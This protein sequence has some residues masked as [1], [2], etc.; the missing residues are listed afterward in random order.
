[1]NAEIRALLR[2]AWGR[3]FTD[4]ER[5]VYWELVAEWTAAARRPVAVGVAA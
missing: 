1:M 5:A 4:A 2:A 3:P